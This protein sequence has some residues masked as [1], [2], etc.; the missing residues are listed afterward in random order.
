MLTIENCLDPAG[1]IQDFQKYCLMADK[2][3]ADPSLLQI[4]LDNVDRW[5]A[6]G[7]RAADKLNKWR[8]L[9]VDAHPSSQGLK[10]L[11][12]LLGD[13]SEETRWF[14]GFSPVAGILTPEELRR[15]PWIS[16]H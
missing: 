7:H 12:D 1:D 2:I 10:K 9:V 5:L 8:T 16:R 13:D 14:K 3:E 4:P 11:L 6:R 15:F